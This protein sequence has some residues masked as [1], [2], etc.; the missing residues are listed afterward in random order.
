MIIKILV[1]VLRNTVY[2]MKDMIT[3]GRFVGKHLIRYLVRA[4]RTYW[5]QKTLT[6]HIVALKKLLREVFKDEYQDLKKKSK[7]ISRPVK[8]LL[9]M[10]WDLLFK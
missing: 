5:D 2:L 6:E 9:R 10:L 3:I 7:V 1:K 4:K 8:R